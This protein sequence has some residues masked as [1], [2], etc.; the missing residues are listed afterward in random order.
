MNKKN[1][2]KKS[3]KKLIVILIII[4]LVFILLYLFNPIVIAKR[5]IKT[6]NNSKFSEDVKIP[7]YVNFIVENNSKIPSETIIK[8]YD[9]FANKIIPT[10]YKKCSQ[11]SSDEINN[12]F[13]RNKQIIEI[14]I[15]IT[16]F[17]EF[18]NFI[19]TIKSLNNSELTLEKY[20]ILDDTI[21]TQGN[22]V[23]VYIGIKYA[24]CED[25]Y[26]RSK[27]LG[28]FKKEK[29]LIT[30][31]SKIDNSRLEKG[32]ITFEKREEEVNNAVSPFT[33]GSVVE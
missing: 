13:K 29:T 1:I 20:Y 10:Y 33:R 25:I 26:F 23:D 5:N 19:N 3:I 22:S 24:N 14:E 7:E 2:E 17:N 6:L 12:Y 27:V 31:N 9:N 11:M 8:Y 32:L 28:F 21:K 16:D 4:L 15:G 18:S 30:F